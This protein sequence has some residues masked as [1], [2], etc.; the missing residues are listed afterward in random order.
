MSGPIWP[1]VES[2]GKRSAQ[3]TEPV[4]L[5]QTGVPIM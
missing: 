5:G 3:Y 1:G 2:A 4:I